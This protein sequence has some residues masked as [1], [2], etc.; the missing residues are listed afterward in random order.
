[1]QNTLKIRRYVWGNCKQSPRQVFLL[2]LVLEVA[3][4]E[5]GFI[6]TQAATRNQGKG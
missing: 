4:K 3:K 5:G 2:G 1:M 6:D